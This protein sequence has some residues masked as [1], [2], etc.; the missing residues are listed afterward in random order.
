MSQ[1]REHGIIDSAHGSTRVGDGEEPPHGIFV[2]SHD[3][4][5]ST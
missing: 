5:C 3:A 2:N 1:K 4:Q